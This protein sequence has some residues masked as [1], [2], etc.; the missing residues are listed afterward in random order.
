MLGQA[1]RLDGSSDD[2]RRAGSCQATLECRS[3][4]PSLKTSPFHRRCLSSSLRHLQPCW[5]T[6]AL[7][8]RALPRCA[9]PGSCA[10]TGGQR[11]CT[12]GMRGT[13]CAGGGCTRPLPVQPALAPLSH[14]GGRE[15]RPLLCA[16]S[17]LTPPLHPAA[18]GGMRS[19]RWSLPSRG[20][21]WWPPT[22]ASGERCAG[23]RGSWAFWSGGCAV[24]L[25]AHGV[26]W[27]LRGCSCALQSGQ[28][29]PSGLLVG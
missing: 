29:A 4:D 16:L 21:A 27:G 22:T 5:C 8:C 26:A 6:A 13:P 1:R 24:V 23:L 7:A 25:A 15:V 10:R 20:A 14:G 12:R 28:A 11:Q 18:S 19:R 17:T 3:C 2:L 9:S